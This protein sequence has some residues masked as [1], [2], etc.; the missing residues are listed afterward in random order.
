MTVLRSKFIGFLEVKGY[1]AAT[2]RNYV[3]VVVQFQRFIGHSPVKLTQDE[4]RDYLLYLKR[5]RKLQVRTLNLHLYGIRSFCNFILPDADIMGPF[6]RMREPKHQVQVLSRE[7]IERVLNAAEDIRDKAVISVMYSSGIR[8]NECAHLK[9]TDIDS[10]RMLVHVHDGK[11]A[12]DRYTLLSP[13][14]LLTL[15]EYW[16]RD[17]PTVY[18]FEGNTPGVP[19]HHRW[20]QEVV[21]RAGRRANIGKQVAP[22]ILRHSL[23]RCS[24]QAFATHLLEAGTPLQVIQQLL[25]HESIA[26][27]AM[28]THVSTDLLRNVKSPFDAPLTPPANRPLLPPEVS[29]P[30]GAPQP[31]RRRRG[32]PRKNERRA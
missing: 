8:L 14:T 13:R 27:T 15:R 21:R 6:D 24:A 29:G 4:I 22:H 11:G 23:R 1:S 18:L 16:L 20:M 25:G 7:E 31:A 32:R 26:T 5:E 2:I 10:N 17:R 3:Q 19:I 28:Y 9:I 12:K 30:A